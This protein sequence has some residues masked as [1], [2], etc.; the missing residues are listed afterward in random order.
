MTNYFLCYSWWGS[1]RVPCPFSVEIFGMRKP[2]TNLV[3]NGGHLFH[4]GKRFLSLGD[5][6][7]IYPYPDFAPSKYK[8]RSD[9]FF[10]P[11]LIAKVEHEMPVEAGIIEAE[12]SIAIWWFFK[13]T[14]SI[15]IKGMKDSFL[16]SSGPDHI[17]VRN[18]AKQHPFGTN[19]KPYVINTAL[20]LAREY[21]YVTGF[22]LS[23]ND[24]SLPW[25]GYMDT[26]SSYSGGHQT[27]RE[28]KDIDINQADSSGVKIPCVDGYVLRFLVEEISGS[29][30]VPYLQCENVNSI[31][32]KPDD[33]TALRYHLNF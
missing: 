27:H 9:T 24:V 21:N 22:R 2:E 32:V 20:T 31:P 29:N 15:Q 28:G 12:T 18:D 14:Y 7:L 5:K 4:T 13:D 10:T 33:P 6:G 8:V 26:K 1:E 17:V 11:K 23:F 19:G 25:G 30:D 3:N 16:A